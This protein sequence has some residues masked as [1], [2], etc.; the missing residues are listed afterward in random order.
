MKKTIFTLLLIAL[1]F[2][3]LDA[4]GVALVT[5]AKGKVDLFR[6]GKNIKFKVGDSI[7]D[8]D[9]IHT[10][11]QSFAAYKYIDDSSSI[12]VFANSYVVVSASRRDKLLDKTIKV[13]SGR[14]FTKVNPN[15]KGSVRVSTP[16]TMA[17]VNGTQFITIV[18]EEGEVTYIVT[19][20]TVNVEVSQ[21]GDK[22]DVTAGQ[23]AFVDRY[24]DLS[25][26]ETTPEDIQGL[27]AAEQEAL[28]VYTPNILR[29]PMIDEDGYTRFIEIEY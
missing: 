6:G 7:N 5:A 17:S 23:T 16:T 19:D 2:T 22:A 28:A 27:D 1:I 3:A 29:I 8:F 20:G 18:N 13:N 14:V 9:E 26:R 10:R 12:K 11:N 4:T 24:M 21:T 25:V 15:S